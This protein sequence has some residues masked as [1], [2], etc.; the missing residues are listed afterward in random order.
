MMQYDREE[1]KDKAKV[2]LLIF[3]IIFL[4]LI[5]ING[6]S[7]EQFLKDE[8][9]LFFGLGAIIVTVVLGWLIN[10]W[11]DRKANDA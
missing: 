10:K 9:I 6:I 5:I 8:G 11:R 3:A 1:E 2:Y 4:P 7:E